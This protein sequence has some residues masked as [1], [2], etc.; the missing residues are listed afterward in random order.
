M[1]YTSRPEDLQLIDYA[2]VLRRRWWLILVITVAGTLA[3]AGYLQAAHK[4]Y[5]A[6]ASVYVTATSGTTNQVANGRT[7]GAVNLDTQAQVV[8]SSAVAQ[9]AAKLMHATDTVPQLLG[10]VSVAVPANSQV[11]A[12]SCQASTPDKAASCAQS[13]AQAYLSYSS[14]ATTASVNSQ[15][16]VLQSKINGLQSASAKLTVA[17]ANLPL[18][19]SQRATAEEQLKS[20]HSQLS[21]LN[22]QVAQLTAAL[23]NPSGGSIISNALPPSKPSSPKPLL[24]V[25]S[26]LLA[27]LLIGLVLAFLTDRRQRRIR[28]PQDVT[29]ADVPVLM[30][31]P[32]RGP[33][34]ELT[35]AAPRSPLGREFSELAHVLTGAMGVGRHVILVSGIIRGQGASLVAANLAAALSR[36]QPDVTLVCAD[37][38]GSVIPDM[39]GLPSEPGL[40]DVLAGGELADDAGRRLAT[41]PRLRV[42]SPGSDAGLDAEDIRQDAMERMLDD[43][44]TDS[45]WVVVEGPAVTS[46][47]DVSTLAHLADAAVLVAEVPRTRSD[48]LLDGVEHLGKMG[49]PVLGVALLPAPRGSGPPLRMASRQASLAAD[50]A[51]QERRAIPAVSRDD[52]P[53]NG[54][55]PAPGHVV[56]D[57]APTA[58]FRN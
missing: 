7:T 25:P 19:S 45:R 32:A 36:N 18:N 10:R 12:I 17:A 41:A 34:P 22:S 46:R 54:D 20:D 48:Q 33:A 13:F 58:P 1:S 23:A 35:L 6:T 51:P 39:V 8:Q 11:L 5:T 40:T 4:V 49:A 27:G 38:E 28:R 3:G 14:A 29:R 55:R 50:A 31:L 21:S 16:S 42:I 52:V 44:R 9:A 2:G 15:I 24:I 56:A 26:G 37:L 43:L 47:P 57:D 30:S 53:V